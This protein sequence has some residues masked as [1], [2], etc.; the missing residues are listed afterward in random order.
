MEA[1]MI[2]LPAFTLCVLMIATHT[3]LGLH[4][5]ARG[6]IFVDL[7]LAQV[8]ALGVSV[9]FLMGWDVHGLYAQ[10]T[11][12]LFTIIAAVVFA[13]LRDIPDKTAREVMIGCIYVVTT[14]MA[15]VILSRSS[16]GMEELKSM[17]SGNILWVRWE[18]VAFLAVV[19][20]A[21]AVLHAVFFRRFKALSFDESEERKSGF[22]C[23]L[24]FFI[25]FALVITLAVNLA[26]V[27]MVF[28][29]L[30]IPAFAA[31]L[32]AHSFFVRLALGCVL[33]VV[34]S[35]V[36]LWLSFSEDLPA[37]PVI[38]AVLGGLPLITGGA[39]WLRRY[40]ERR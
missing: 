20:A 4:V 27:L 23:E 19:Y 6:I 1:W 36:G 21:L 16:Q 12:L 18:E 11:A 24:V 33:A 13:K 22:K 2:L 34:G 28:A 40:V 30:I 37:G 9:A 35:I 25:S 14:A 3:Y 29:F 5:L 39:L 31:S 32:L 38:V 8:A 15:I 26:G 17:F 10:L 7:A